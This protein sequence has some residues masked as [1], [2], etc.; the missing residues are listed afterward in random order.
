[1]QGDAQFTTTY[2]VANGK[3]LSAAEDGTAKTLHWG[4]TNVTVTVTDEDGNTF[5]DTC[6]VQVKCRFWQWL[7]IIILFGWFWY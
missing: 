1:M 6:A 3:M 2:K 4:K 7:I 5:S